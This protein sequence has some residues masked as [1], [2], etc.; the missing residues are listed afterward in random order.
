[1]LT[2]L[3]KS[4]ILLS[5]ETETIKDRIKSLRKH[6]KLTQDAFGKQIGLSDVAISL[7]ESGKNAVSETVFKLICFTFSVRE[8]WLRDGKGDPYEKENNEIEKL[9]SIYRLLSPS[10]K[11]DVCEFAE[12][13]LQRKSQETSSESDKWE[14]PSAPAD[15]RKSLPPGDFTEERSVG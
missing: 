8:E 5:M 2:F 3:E 4:Y 1:M 9:L 15:S 14:S 7:I 13:C 6:K 11:Q 10:G 12:F